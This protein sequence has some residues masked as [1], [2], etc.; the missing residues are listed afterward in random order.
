[1]MMGN[2]RVADELLVI[3]FGWPGVSLGPLGAWTDSHILAPVNDDS[4]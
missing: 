1:M 2:H 4:W 3:V